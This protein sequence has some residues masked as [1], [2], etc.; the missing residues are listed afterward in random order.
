[1]VKI[2]TDILLV[3]SLQDTNKEVN[4]FRKSK[5]ERVMQ[6]ALHQKCQGDIRFVTKY[7]GRHC[8]LLVSWGTAQFKT[9]YHQRVVAT[10]PGRSYLIC[11]ICASKHVLLLEEREG[12]RLE[13]QMGGVEQRTE[14]ESGNSL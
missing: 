13:G 2:A 10:V 12:E 5:R 1:M 3:Q 7:H 8:S 6:R 9:S 11:W 14:K 4:R